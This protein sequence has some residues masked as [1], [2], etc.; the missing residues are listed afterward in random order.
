MTNRKALRIA[1]VL[2]AVSGATFLTASAAAAA[3]A[4]DRKTC[5]T[6]PLGTNLH[7]PQDT[8]RD[9]GGQYTS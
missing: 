1:A 4:P 5:E 7:L 6:Y 2:T 8:C 3:P 9:H